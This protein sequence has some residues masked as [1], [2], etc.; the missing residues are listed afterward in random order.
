[1]ATSNV[2]PPGQGTPPGA[3]APGARREN[4]VLPPPSATPVPPLSNVPVN[5]P[6]GAASPGD[7]TPQLSPPPALANTPPPNA[8][9]SA[10]PPEGLDEYCPVTLVEK[11]QWVKGDQRYGVIHRGRTYLFAGPEEQ[12][13]FYHNPDRYAPINSGYDVVLALDQ[14]QNVSGKRAHGVYYLDHVFLFADEASLARFSGNP[15][16]YANQALEALRTSPSLK[17]PPR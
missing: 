6:S 17:P 16:Y 13:R 12:T 11:Q 9:S 10:N 15:A 1:M 4:A 2:A 8:V 14:G 3:A 5:P 7:S